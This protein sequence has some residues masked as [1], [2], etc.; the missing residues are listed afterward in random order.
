MVEDV[1]G[2]KW[3][4]RLLEL[5]ADGCSRPG[6][7]LRACEGLSAKV[8]N[9]RFRKMVGYGIVRRSVFGEKPPLEVQ[10]EL[11]AFGHRFKKVIGEIR[12][13]QRDLENST[14]VEQGP[15]QPAHASGRQQKRRMP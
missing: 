6:A 12:C 10:Y 2:C 14:F 13:L 5:V 1:V 8:M 9:E 4:I 7:L 11:T 15:R 3:S